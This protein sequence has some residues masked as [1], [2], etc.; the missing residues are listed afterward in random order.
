VEDPFCGRTFNDVM[1]HNTHAHRMLDQGW[2]FYCHKQYEK[3]LEKYCL[4]QQSSPLY[5][6]SLHLQALAHR[7]IGHTQIAIELLKHSL[8]LQPTNA[9]AWSDLG[10]LHFQLGHNQQVIACFQ[11][12]LNLVPDDWE[13]LRYLGLSCHALD[14][15]E[16]ALRC[17][18]NMMAI[19]PDHTEAYR[20]AAN[21]LFCMGRY[22]EALELSDRTM[23]LSSTDAEAWN[24]RAA[25]YFAMSDFVR[26]K[27]CAEEALKIA[28][29]YA[30]AWTT[31]T[32]ALA[33]LADYMQARQCLMRALEI[34]SQNATLYF[35]LG[36]IDF[37]ELHYEDALVRFEQALTIDPTYQEA[38]CNHAA[39]LLKMERTEEAIS[40]LQTLL[41]LAPDQAQSLNN[42]GVLYLTKGQYARALPLFERAVSLK[43]D[44]VDALMNLGSAME[45]ERQW[46]R[47]ITY[48]SRAYEH[49]PDHPELLGNLLNAKLRSCD[50]SNWE[51]L[52]TRLLDCMRAGKDVCAPLRALPLAE[53]A[54]LLKTYVA[55]YCAQT[56]GEN[57]AAI[58]IT[59]ERRKIRVGYYSS[60]FREHPV[61][62]LMAEI[63]EC[64]DRDHFEILGFTYNLP[65]KGEMYK[66]IARSMDKIYDLDPLSHRDAVRMCRELQLDVAVDLARFTGRSRAGIFIDRVAPVQINY[67]GYPSTMGVANWDCVIADEVV[68][69]A[70]H[71]SYY[72]EKVIWLPGCFQANSTY[73]KVEDRVYA[74]EDLGLP[75]D[76]F[77]FCCFNGLNKLQPSVFRL[78]MSILRQVPDSVLWL[79]NS[80]A[81]A[82]QNLRASAEGLGVAGERIVFTE[83]VSLPEHHARQRAAD[84]FLDTM[85]FNA[86][87]TASSS[88][89]VGLPIL[90]CAGDT[91]SARMGASLLLTPA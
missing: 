60:D 21:V 56:Y 19:R 48:Y 68:V 33:E 74:R 5:P 88:L 61:A 29:R 52:T 64:H 32:Q 30:E 42:L 77:V 90:I 4:V 78:W 28:P 80:N 57:S 54:A 75:R 79:V 46:D 25:T 63:F 1:S 91:F 53:D 17:F 11:M 26:S 55:S 24:N 69:P 43:A 87:A 18:K 10:K 16:E 70:S 2:R 89:R 41:A 65:D 58:A 27:E 37:K 39:C 45:H 34:D 20:Y 66:R 13:A 72:G 51:T 3:A 85:P 12:R 86:G 35:K 15:K 36:I 22:Q 31:C 50:W 40:A 62:Y 6:A 14:N 82:K 23:Q 8:H 44:Y 76:G 81:V 59:S 83:P 67:I 71:R 38:R 47:A 7:E 49:A 84:L 9:Q 73:L